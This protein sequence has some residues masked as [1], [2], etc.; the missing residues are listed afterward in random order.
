MHTFVAIYKSVLDNNTSSVDGCKL[1]R[2]SS[3]V[4]QVRAIIL[5]APNRT[6][7]RNAQDMAGEKFLS[8]E[9][10]IEGSAAL[11]LA[12]GQEHIRRWDED[13]MVVDRGALGREGALKEG[14]QE[15]V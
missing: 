3:H 15:G 7:A 14:S 5:N 12:E 6:W 8:S 2:L 10:F 11:G 4:T 9:D 13:N 1:L